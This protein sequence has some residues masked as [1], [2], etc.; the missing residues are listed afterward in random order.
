MNPIERFAALS[1]EAQGRAIASLSPADQRKVFDGLR[2]LRDHVERTKFYRMFPDTGPLRR[3][4]YAKHLEF[5]RLGASKKYRLFLG[6]TGT[7][8]TEGAGGYEAVCHLTGEYPAWWEGKRFNKPIRMWIGANSLETFRDSVQVKLFG[9]REAWGT[10]LIPA[11]RIGKPKFYSNPTDTLDFCLIKHVN[12]GWSR[13]IS[14]SYKGGRESF[15]SQDVDAIWLDEEP[16]GEILGA[17]SGRFRG[18]TADGTLWMTYTPFQGI[19]DVVMGYVPQFIPDYNPA[20]YEA[21]GKAL[22]ICAHTDVPHKTPDSTNW[23][24]HEKEARLNGIPSTGAGKVYQVPESD[25][26]IEPL[27]TLPKHWPRLFGADFGF[28]NSTSVVF[29]AH[30]V[31]SDC[32]YIYAEYK[33]TQAE[34]EVHMGA[35]K[36]MGGTWIPGVGDYA[37]ANLEGERTLELYKRIGLPMH[38]ADKT[39]KNEGVLEVMTRLS[40]GRMK[41]YNT[42]QKWLQEYRLYSRD[43]RGRVVKPEGGD[44]LMDATRYL[45]RDIRRAIT[46]PI[47]RSSTQGS[48]SID[49]FTRR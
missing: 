28:S 32:I 2:K 16:D 9:P 27:A 25:F 41:V 44:D 8:K 39:Q 26:V 33:R 48:G 38:K 49:F 34:P 7:G 20:V 23:L 37:G 10:G 43:E 12:G 35:I 1:P 14:R 30:D 3:E 21:S 24:P 5:F 47:P 22:I 19:T 17:A 29:G 46:K 42:C 13:L 15:E 45:V 6:G 40:Q 4:L 11:A 31:D 18:H 36:A